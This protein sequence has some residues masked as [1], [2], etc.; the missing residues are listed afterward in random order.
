MLNKQS[1]TDEYVVHSWYRDAPLPTDPAVK[2]VSFYWKKIL[3]WPSRTMDNRKTSFY[4]PWSYT[5]STHFIFRNIDF[6]DREG[7]L[8][9]EPQKTRFW[10]D[11]RRIEKASQDGLFPTILSLNFYHVIL[12]FNITPVAARTVER[13]RWASI[14]CLLT[15][16]SSLYRSIT[17]WGLIAKTRPVNIL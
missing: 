15:C 5:R 17:S 14:W 4:Y 2:N 11:S 3:N 9:P 12:Y 7:I 1:C 16:I 8:Y 13:T 10:I 6:R